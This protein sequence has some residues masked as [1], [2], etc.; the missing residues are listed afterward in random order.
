MHPAPWCGVWYSSD[1]VPA[2]VR[3]GQV[4]D[5]F[6]KRAHREDMDS[7]VEQRKYDILAEKDDQQ[8]QNT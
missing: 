3:G 6:L 4:S 8:S 5:E 2:L 7:G 1:R